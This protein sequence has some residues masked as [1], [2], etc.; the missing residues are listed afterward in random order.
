M[1]IP[2][3]ELLLPRPRRCSVDP[4][5]SMALPP[6]LVV[7][8][9]TRCRGWLTRALQAEGLAAE[10][11]DRAPSSETPAVKLTLDPDAPV[12]PRQVPP[13]LRRQGYALELAAH[14]VSIT[15]F[16]PA[17]LRHGAA[18]LVQW[19]RLHRLWRAPG[20]ALAGLRV[21]DWPDLAVRGVMLD[22]SRDKV[23]TMRT[24][25]ALVELL[26]GL[27]INQLQLY[28]EHTFAYAGHEVVWR[29]ASPMTAEQVRL[30]DARCQQL[31]VELVPN[32]NSLGHFHRWLVHEPYRALAEC[33]DGVEHPFS[34]EREPFSLCATDPAAL[35]LLGDLYDQLL[36]NFSS[37]QLNV[38][39]DETFD[40]GLGRSAAACARQG[41]EEVYLGFLRQVHRLARQRG[42]RMQFWGDIIIKRP[43]LIE[44]L[45]DDVIALEWGYEADHP[46][47]RHAPLLAASGRQF[48][49]CPGTSSWN[50]L[51]GRV[52]NALVNLGRAAVQGHQHGA[53]GYLIT[54]WGDHGHLQPLPVSYPGLLAGAGFS[55]NVDS[56]SDP[57]ALPLA[58]L[59]DSHAL[60]DRRQVLGPALVTLGN[61]Y[62]GIG[63]GNFN[64]TALFKLLRFAHRPLSDKRFAGLD[65]HGLAA[66]QQ[67]VEQV[68]QALAAAPPAKAPVDDRVDR[69]LVWVA[70]LLRLACQLG[71]Q[72][73]AH[74]AETAALPAAQRQQLRRQLEPLVQ[75]HEPLWLARNRP[76]GRRDSVRWLERLAELLG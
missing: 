70:G 64:G 76:G 44:Q 5:D 69:E 52:D 32:Q 51:A 23:P 20:A 41:T 15:G 25:L 33:P 62:Q 55:W 19:A 13:E 29:D 10:E 63:T 40:L 60:G 34:A 53:A 50:S 46:F 47:E 39:L 21:L 4:G 3:Q 26:A 49:V 24:L 16:G 58:R 11:A 17:G 8:G 66:A 9:D 57:R 27:K 38:G 28:I 42:R 22:I 18:T 71:R 72:R 56:A 30:L 14:G 54:D 6:R 31:G 2:L 59:L 7:S 37:Q 61:A 65:A 73:L 36:P 75:E 67:R 45:P 12:A 1:E 35:G 43:D 74:G 68:A 48:C